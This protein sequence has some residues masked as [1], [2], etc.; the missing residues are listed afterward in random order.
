DTLPLSALL[1]SKKPYHHLVKDYKLDRNINND[2]FVDASLAHTLLHEEIEKFNQL[3][4]TMKQIYYSLLFESS[5]FS[6]FFKYVKYYAPFIRLSA[7][8]KKQFHNKICDNAPLHDLIKNY[9]EELAYC[10][11]IIYES[12]TDSIAPEWVIHKYKNYHYVMDQLR[13]TSCHKCDYCNYHMNA[14]IALQ[15]FFNYPNFRT[16]DGVNLQEQVVNAQLNG[17]SIVAVFPTAGGKSLTFQLPALIMGEAVKGLTVVIS[18][19]QSLMNDQIENLKNQSINDVGTINGSQNVLERLETLKRVR[20]GEIHILYLAPESLRSPSILKL[21]SSR[22]LVRFVIDEA[23]CF[24]TWGHDFRVD[25]QYIAEF[26]QEVLKSSSHQK[27]VPISCFTA[28]AKQEV[29]DDIQA[30]FNQHLNVSLSVYK[31]NVR[32]INLT[33]YVK[34]CKGH[35]QKM[36]AIKDLLDESGEQP[37]IIYAARRKIAEKISEE[38]SSYGYNATVYHGGMHIEAKNTNQLD[39]TRGEKNIIVATSAFG[40]GVDKK[41][42]GYVIHYHV[43]PTIED[44]LQEAGRGGRDPQIQAKCYILY[45]EEDINLHFNLLTQS[46]LS[47]TDINTVWRTIKKETKKH[48]EISISANELAR[49]SGWDEEENP[50][51]TRVT[52]SILALEK[53]SYVKRH[54]NAPRVFASSILPKTMVEASQVIENLTNI[55]DQ[56]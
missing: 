44:Y 56:D 55:N 45:D 9:P 12:D 50:V 20:D 32:R 39:F 34:N 28:T 4:E 51:E 54:Q 40:M 48:H 35:Q 41:D 17:D 36:S 14:T 22:N 11:S 29:I 18:P 3:P 43:S 25:Y 2:P 21:L 19:L 52:H 47:H 30:Y 5:D 46:K 1:Y 23:H 27:Q 24:S 10:L 33:Y 16:F 7:L 53:V 42:V 49:R 31:T 13:G 38:L 37:V 15:R 26:I 8:I 6:A